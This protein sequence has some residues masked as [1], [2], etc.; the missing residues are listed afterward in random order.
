MHDS[1]AN[2]AEPSCRGLPQVVAHYCAH[3]MARLRRVDRL[4][5]LACGLFLHGVHVRAP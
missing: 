3:P 5:R 4:I 1:C 2:N